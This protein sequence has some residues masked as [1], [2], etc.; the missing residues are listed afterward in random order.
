MKIKIGYE[1]I[2]N[3]PQVTPMV[4]MVNVHYSRASDM[5]I[6]DHLTTEPR[7]RSPHI[8]MGSETGATGS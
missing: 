6:Q 7:Y 1:L 4:L 3:F 8:G 5:V 2:Y